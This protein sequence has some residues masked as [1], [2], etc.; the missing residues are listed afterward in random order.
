VNSTSLSFFKFCV[1]AVLWLLVLSCLLVALLFVVM[2]ES[3]LVLSV[4]VGVGGGII[5][6]KKKYFYIT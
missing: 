4:A 5:P 6:E 1:L 2:F 3:C